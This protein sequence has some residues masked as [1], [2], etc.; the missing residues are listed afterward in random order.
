MVINFRIINN[1]MGWKLFE[2][3]AAIFNIIDATD[4]TGS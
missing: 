2:I 1:Y 4:P 3:T